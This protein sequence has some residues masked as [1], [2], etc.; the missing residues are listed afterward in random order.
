[1]KNLNAVPMKKPLYI[2]SGFDL[3]ITVLPCINVFR[4][5]CVRALARARINNRALLA[6]YSS[7]MNLTTGSRD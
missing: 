7:V 2:V 4:F 6:P 3:N 5:P 1:M